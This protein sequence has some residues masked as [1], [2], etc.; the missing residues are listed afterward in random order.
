MSKKFAEKV[1]CHNLMQS[2][3]ENQY[4]TAMK[5]QNQFLHKDDFHAKKAVVQI[6]NWIEKKYPGL[7]T[8]TKTK[9]IM[10]CLIELTEERKFLATH[11]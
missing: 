2:I 10:E 3:F 11:R 4:P 7:T 1:F 6:Q 8:S 5:N 9:M